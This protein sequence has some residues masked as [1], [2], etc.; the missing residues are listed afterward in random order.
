MARPDDLHPVSRSPVPGG[1][2]RRSENLEIMEQEKLVLGVKEFTGPAL[3][4]MLAK[5]KYHPLVG[6]VR[7]IGLLG[8]IELVANKRARRRFAAPARV[9]L[10]CRDHFFREGFIMRHVFDTMVT[11]PP[12]IWRQEQFDEAQAVIGR[13]LDLTLSDVAGEL[14]A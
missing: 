2:R 6:E 12:L 11:A 9:G 8:A 3:A 1:V 14:A 10:I 13:V 4:K 5:L 7:S